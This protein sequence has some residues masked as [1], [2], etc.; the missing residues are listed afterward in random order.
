MR[1]RMASLVWDFRDLSDFSSVVSRELGVD[2]PYSS[3]VSDWTTFFRDCELQD[4]LDL[5]TVGY[6]YL[7]DKKA[8]GLKESN[9]STRWCSE[10][11]R[12]FAEENVHYR[13]DEKGGV[14]FHFDAEFSSNQAATIAALQSSRYANVAAEFD[15]AMVALSKAPPDGK[16]AI[17]GTFSAAEGLF[18][19]MFPK[20]PRLTAQEAQKL[21]PLLQ[22]TYANSVASGAAMKVLSAFKDWIDAAHFYRHEA[23]HEDPV[24]PPLTLSVQIVSVGATFIRWLAELDSLMQSRISSQANHA[25]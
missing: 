8:T 19:L 22:M 23:G 6:R 21:E 12:I 2:V 9:P 11:Q 4:V 25:S 16:S 24:Q 18:R 13:V 10:A 15:G 17:R 1:R 5:V 20:S 7:E 3:M 14:H